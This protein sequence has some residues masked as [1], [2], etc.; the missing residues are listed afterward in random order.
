M[1]VEINVT[2]PETDTPVQNTT[3]DVTVVNGTA[4][5]NMTIV[6]TFNETIPV[7][8]NMTQMYSTDYDEEVPNDFED[9]ELPHDEFT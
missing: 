3:L 5:Y 4:V 2:G 1:P 8:V 6:A 7:L 9:H